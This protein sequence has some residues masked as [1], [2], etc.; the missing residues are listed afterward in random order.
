MHVPPPD[1]TLLMIPGPTRVS[2]DVLAAG[3]RPVLSHSDPYFVGSAA[4]CLVGL[5][6]L[7]GAPSAQPIVVAGSGT[8]AMEIG[9]VNLVEPGD[10]VLILETGVFAR[11]FG[12]IL[13]RNQVEYRIEAAPMGQPIDPDQVRQAL[14]EYRPKV[15]TITHVDTS[16]GVRVDVPTLSRIGRDHGALIVVD[17]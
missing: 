16:T 14:A 9:I 6:Q 11:R 12:A 4:K 17:G 2:P 8:L 15:M 5:R 10:R 1:R 7:F 13:E 3:S